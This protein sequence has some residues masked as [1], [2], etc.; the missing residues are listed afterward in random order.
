MARIGYVWVGALEHSA[1]FQRSLIVKAGATRIFEDVSPNT[2]RPRRPQLTEA[3][4][5]IGKGDSLVVWRLDRLG[6]TT[7]NVLS[8]LELL[9]RREVG[10]A[11]IAEKIDTAAEGGASLLHLIGAINEL[12]RCLIRERTMVG[13]YAAHARGRVAGRPKALS[14]TNV[15]RVVMLRDQGASVREIAEQLGTSRATI[16]RALESA[17]ETEP[18]SGDRQTVIVRFPSLGEAGSRPIADS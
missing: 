8:L 3:L 10:V 1:E 15:E 12:E 14:A 9:G 4:D 16:Y 18:A 17:V 11:S 6:S 7:Q 2:S 13:V 5:S